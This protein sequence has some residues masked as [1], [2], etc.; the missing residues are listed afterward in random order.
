M[1]G[2]C[3]CVGRKVGVG[4]CIFWKK[5]DRLTTGIGERH[6]DKPHS[7]PTHPTQPQNNTPVGLPFPVLCCVR[8]HERGRDERDG[9]SREQESE[10]QK[11]YTESNVFSAFASVSERDKA[12]QDQTTTQDQGTQHK[13]TQDQ[14]PLEKTRRDKIA[15]Y[16]PRQRNTHSTAT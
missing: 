9:E 4:S 5:A 14:K 6:R 7:T 13:T 8:I 11:C 2:V 16:N 10:K 1:K 12:R 15:Q 3:V